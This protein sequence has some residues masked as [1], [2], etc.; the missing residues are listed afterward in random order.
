MTKTFLAPGT[1][2]RGTPLTEE[3]YTGIDRILQGAIPI[4]V[5]RENLGSGPFLVGFGFNS[6]HSI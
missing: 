2:I 4:P 5:G 3:G 6:F 1:I